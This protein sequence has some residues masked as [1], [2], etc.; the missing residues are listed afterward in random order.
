MRLVRFEFVAVRYG[1]VQTQR[2]LPGCGDLSFEL[3]IPRR[4][5]RSVGL[6]VE[7]DL[8]GQQTRRIARFKYDTSEAR[9]SCTD[10]RFGPALREFTASNLRAM[11]DV[12]R[13][14]PGR[15]TADRRCDI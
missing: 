4:Q 15:V 12:D 11:S 5:V 13:F 1:S 3:H 7:N 9:R 6:R 14:T 8:S 2:N 10:A